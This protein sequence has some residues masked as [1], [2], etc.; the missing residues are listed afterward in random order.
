MSVTIGEDGLP[1][2]KNE[3]DEDGDGE[4]GDGYDSGLADGMDADVGSDGEDGAGE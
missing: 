1:L 4:Q 3:I 2:E